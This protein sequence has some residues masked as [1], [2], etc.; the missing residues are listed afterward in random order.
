M[1]IKMNKDCHGLKQI[2]YI[3]IH[4]FITIFKKETK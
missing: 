2:K 1:R 4:A 3:K